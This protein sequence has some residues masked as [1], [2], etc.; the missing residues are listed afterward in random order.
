MKLG[1]LV[2]KR[3]DF[4]VRERLRLGLRVIEFG[5]PDPKIQD[6]STARGWWIDA[7]G[8]LIFWMG[9]ARSTEWA[10]FAIGFFAL[11]LFDSFSV[12]S[13]SSWF[14]Y[15][16]LAAVCLSVALVERMREEQ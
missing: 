11:S 8:V 10:A 9:V 7:P 16:V 15:F 13:S 1:P 12:H 14:N 5:R 6:T 3:N 4:N 2:I